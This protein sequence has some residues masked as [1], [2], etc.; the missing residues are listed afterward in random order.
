VHA[1]HARAVADVAVVPATRSTAR[2][3]ALA[4][5]AAMFVVMACG[6]QTS[7]ATGS[8]TIGGSGASPGTVA[9]P[10]PATE[11]PAPETAP[12]PGKP[13]LRGGQPLAPGS[14]T[15]IQG[16]EHCGWGSATFLT[17]GWPLGVVPRDSTQARLY[18]RDPDGLF[19]DRTLAPFNA[20]T[21]LPASA[22]DTGYRYG[23]DQLW[24][25][26]ASVDG[27]VYLVRGGVVEQWPRGRDDIGCA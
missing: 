14:I 5:L 7:T 9:G 20:S 11:L 13:W 21:L 4:W 12:F 8:G 15:L 22:V 2:G 1:A 3:V 10:A 24:M 18:V 26:E 6:L 19:A 16:P 25:D 27:L 17:I 23:T